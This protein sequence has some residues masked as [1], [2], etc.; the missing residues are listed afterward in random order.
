MLTLADFDSTASCHENVFYFLF[1]ES[2]LNFV[3]KW[4]KK[5]LEKNWMYN[6][7]HSIFETNKEAHL[8]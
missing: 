4:K 3:I 5:F 8:E 6:L 1:F 7:F 2:Y